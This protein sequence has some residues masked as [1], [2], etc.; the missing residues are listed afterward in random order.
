MSGQARS[1]PPE[2][3]GRGDGTPGKE[4]R[5]CQILS[6]LAILP[7]PLVLFE[8]FFVIPRYARLYHDHGVETDGLTA[9]FFAIGGVIR[10]QPFVAFL[11]TALLTLGTVAITA[12]WMSAA[13]GKTS[14]R[15]R[16][17]M[18]LL[19]FAIP[20]LLFVATWLGMEHV[21]RRLTTALNR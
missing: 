6:W 4:P 19:P 13:T 8:W 7:W 9:A 3:R 12:A 1:D 5:H 15:W 10:R 18:L 14:G 2:P 16:R 11:T 17:L 21:H 20:F